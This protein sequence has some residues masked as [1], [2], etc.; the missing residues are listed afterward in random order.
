MLLGLKHGTVYSHHEGSQWPTV[1]AFVAAEERTRI[2]EGSTSTC[3]HCLG[4]VQEYWYVPHQDNGSPKP[5]PECV[6][7]NVCRGDG[8]LNLTG[9][10]SH[11][12]WR[13]SHARPPANLTCKLCYE[14]EAND[15]PPN[16]NHSD[17]VLHLIESHVGNPQQA[18]QI[19]SIL[20][21]IG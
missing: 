16:V 19:E 3:P 8:G 11:V 10:R 7:C 4:D 17:L 6:C 1:L 2:M 15:L 5:L 20:R 9:L 14:D 18:G 13:G 21:E 12:L